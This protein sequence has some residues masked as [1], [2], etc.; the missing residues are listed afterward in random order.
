MTFVGL[1][2]HKR[3]ITACALDAGGAV[4]E[5]V[6]RMRPS[7]DALSAFLAALPGPI[8]IGVEATLYW[9]WLTDRLERA[10]HV[11]RVE[12]VP[13]EAHLAGALQD[14]SDR[15]AQV[16]GAAARE[17]HDYLNASKSGKRDEA[18]AQMVALAKYPNVSVK[19]SGIANFSTEPYPFRDAVPYIRRLFDAYGP[20][21]CYWGTD[22]T[23]SFARA[24]YRQRIEQFTVEL[25]FLSEQDKDWIMGRGIRA[26]L[27]WA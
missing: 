14:R 27:G 25:P 19:L 8:T 4:L 20:Q 24:T 22:I 7:L 21:R 6:G 23:N 2:L 26:R 17:P 1:D 10:G 5:E 18:F 15:C 13:G 9:M 16:G 3:S 12:P 11:V